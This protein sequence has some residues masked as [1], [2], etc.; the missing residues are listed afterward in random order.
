MT[1][2]LVLL[3]QQ[4]KQNIPLADRQVLLKCLMATQPNDIDSAL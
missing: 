4:S 2:K 1:Y 3:L